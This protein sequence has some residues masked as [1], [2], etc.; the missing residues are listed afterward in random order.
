MAAADVEMAPGDVHSGPSTSAPDQ[1]LYIKLK[2]LQRQM[3]FL[4]I[5]VRYQPCLLYKHG[6]TRAPMPEWQHPKGTSVVICWFG[7]A[8]P[9][10]ICVCCCHDSIKSPV[11]AVAAKFAG[12][13]IALP[14][15]Q[16]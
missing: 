9:R 16:A 14:C 7:L 13:T 3:E 5:Q 15:S 6:S 4:D 2:T 12:C 11:K 8:E 1:D 10:A